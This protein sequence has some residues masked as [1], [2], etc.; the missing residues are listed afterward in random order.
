MRTQTKKLNQGFTIIE[1]LIVLAIA[2]L[3]LAIIFLAVPALQRNSRNNS[4][5]NDAAKLAGL[6]NDYA[7]NHGGQL[8]TAYCTAGTCGATALDIRG[9]NWAIFATPATI[10]TSA[11]ANYGAND[12]TTMVQNQGWKCSAGVLG[13]YAS[14]S[15]SF[16]IAYNVETSGGV[17]TSC[18]QG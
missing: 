9:E 10:N 17:Q 15:R 8:P 6:V 12:G 13:G 7:S 16:A 4:R 18:I 11:T 3:I 14:G 2:G 5:I 1:V